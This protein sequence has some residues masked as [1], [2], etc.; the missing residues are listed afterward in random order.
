MY[1]C[2]VAINTITTNNND[3]YT[4]IHTYIHTYKNNKNKIS[5]TKTLNKLNL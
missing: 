5:K 2:M 1:V 3:M 4:Y